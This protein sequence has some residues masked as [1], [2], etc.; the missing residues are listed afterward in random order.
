[1]SKTVWNKRRRILRQHESHLSPRPLVNKPAK[2]LVDLLLV[3]LDS[4][5]FFPPTHMIVIPPADDLVPVPRILL[6]V[7]A[8]PEN[9]S[10]P[11]ENC[12][13][14]KLLREQL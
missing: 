5:M 11:G 13:R 3:C 2:L 10:F 14:Y 6:I 12:V 7:T 8:V 9:A 4:F 1:M